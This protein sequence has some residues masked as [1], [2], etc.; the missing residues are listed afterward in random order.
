VA[1]NCV[2][3]SRVLRDGPFKRLFVQPAAGDAGGA[4]GAAALTHLNHLSRTSHRGTG[5]GTTAA[6]RKPSSRLAHVY[7]G[8]SYTNDDIA[9]L[10]ESSGITAHDFRGNEAGLIANTAQRLADG[11]IVGW[12]HGRMEFGP[13]A[14]GARSILADPRV[15]DMQSRVNRLIKNREGFRPFAPAVLASRAAEH[16]DIDHPSPF[17]LE[18]FPVISDTPLPAITHVDRSARVQTVDGEAAPRFHALLEAFNARTGC[19]MLLNT[20]FNLSDEPIVQSPVD[21]LLSFARSRL[22]ALVLEDFIVDRAALPQALVESV[23]ELRP[24]ASG[25]SPLTRVYTF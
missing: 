24:R 11:G 25:A 5:A 14:L 1:L 9:D 6:A 12:F 17:M 15:A 20:S 18:T 23:H 21:A 4:L 8:P 7:L 13:R 22:D 16:F 2:A 3:N 19:P 10:L